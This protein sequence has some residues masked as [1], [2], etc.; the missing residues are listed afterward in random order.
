MKKWIKELVMS[1]L[2]AASLGL[3]AC[4]SDDDGGD[5]PATRISGD[6]A[7]RLVEMDYSDEYTAYVTLSRK[8]A[9]AVACEVTCEK[10]HLQL[11]SIILDI[12]QEGST[13]L[14]S[15]ETK[16]VT[17]SIIGKTLSLTFKV[18]SSSSYVTWTYNFTG[19]RQ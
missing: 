1:L 18:E 10:A 9:T 6:Y 14:L 8:S 13:Y 3:T 4:S 12:K 5:D 17:G 11:H 2:A 7:G 16:A 19:T 15:S